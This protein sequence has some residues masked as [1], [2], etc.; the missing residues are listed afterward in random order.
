MFNE[1]IILDHKMNEILS[2][3]KKDKVIDK[4]NH[5]AEFMLFCYFCGTK[6]QTDK[7]EGNR[8]F[9]YSN[10]KDNKEIVINII[11]I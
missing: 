7:Q 5:S 9:F 4:T 6:L 10:I 11:N 8:N 2:L 1:R 3:L